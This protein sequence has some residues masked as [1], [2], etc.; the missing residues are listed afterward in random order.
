VPTAADNKIHNLK[1]KQNCGKSYLA[2]KLNR[3]LM[4]KKGS[5]LKDRP[6]QY[7]KQLKH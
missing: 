2:V 5:Y 7:P 3:L 1:N 6:R 4:F